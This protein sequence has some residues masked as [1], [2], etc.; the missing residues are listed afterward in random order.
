MKLSARTIAAWAAALGVAMVFG[1]G[2]ES[3]GLRSMR[4]YMQQQNW[5]KALEQGKVAVAENPQ[6][7]DAWFAIAQVSSQVDSVDLMLTAFE[8]TQALTPKYNDQIEELRTYKYNDI[9]NRGVMKYNN[10][11]YAEADALMDQ[12]IDIDPARPN[13]YRVGGMIKQRN[14]DNDTAIEYYGKAWEADKDDIEIGK[15][16]ASQLAARGDVE[17]SVAVFEDLY[18]RAPDNPDV[19]T[20]FLVAL[21]ANDQLD[22]SLEVAGEFLANAPRNPSVNM[23]TGVVYM[24]KARIARED[25]VVKVEN[26]AKAA[27]HFGVAADSGNVDAAFNMALCL[28]QL[29]RIDDALQ[30]MLGVLE[31]SPD[32]HQARLKAAEFLMQLE[33]P[34]EAEAQLQAIVSGIG[35]PTNPTDMRVMGNAYRYLQIIYTFKSAEVEQQAQAL[36]QEANRMRRGSADRRAKEAEAAQLREQSQ[37]LFQ[38]AQ[39]YEQQSQNY[40]ID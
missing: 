20:G 27:E 7:A 40:R 24:E 30:P 37:A 1:I 10:T 2:C 34:D 14:G 13:A 32:D 26:L 35:A 22:R 11:E 36:S 8:H 12:A 38:Q 4:I 28:Q 25:S 21:K 9:F 31:H 33:R 19:V 6:D 29:D 17:Q 23:Q 18:T 39:A 3:V 15:V 5:P 16:Y